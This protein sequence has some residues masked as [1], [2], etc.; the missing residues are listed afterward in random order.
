[1][2]NGRRNQY[3]TY[4]QGGLEEGTFVC[5]AGASAKRISC[6]IESIVRIYASSSGSLDGERR[7]VIDDDDERP[8]QLE[9]AT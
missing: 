2:R 1:M 4:T 7:I 6:F 9:N 8:Q 3:H 5:L